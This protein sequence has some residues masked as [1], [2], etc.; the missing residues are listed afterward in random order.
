[1]NTAAIRAVGAGIVISCLPIIIACEPQRANSESNEESSAAFAYGFEAPGVV[2]ELFGFDLLANDDAQLALAMSRKGGEMFYSQ[3]RIGETGMSLE[4]MHSQYVD[5]RWTAPRPAFFASEHGEIEAFFNTDGDRL[6]FFSRRPE[7]EP[8]TRATRWNLWYVERSNEG[9]SQP[10]L[11]GQPDSLVVR[12]WSANLLNDTTLYFTARPYE[13]HIL[14]EIFEVSIAGDNFGEPRTAGSGINTRE[15]TENEPALAP[16]GS[17]MVF[18]SAGRPDNL[19]DEMVGDLYISFRG[20]D[21]SWQEAVRLDEPINST[22]EENWPRISPDGQFLFFSSNRREG[23]EFPDLYWVSTEAL[24][25]YR[26]R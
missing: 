11:L 16:D 15:F 14:A 3:I 6:Y 19:S 1:M 24:E 9:W 10:R 23:V 25:R 13:E 17:Y 7:T 12:N 5:G 18:Y 2:P 22:D 20:E 4:Q 21:G 26:N 8:V